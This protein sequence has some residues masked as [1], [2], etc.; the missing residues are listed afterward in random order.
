MR[1]NYKRGLMFKRAFATVPLIVAALWQFSIAA[2][3]LPKGKAA[4]LGLSE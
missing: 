3:E 1:L 4:E 2:Q